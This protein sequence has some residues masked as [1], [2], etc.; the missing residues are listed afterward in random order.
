MLGLNL[1]VYI[2]YIY[3][4]RLCTGFVS[5]HDQTIREQIVYRGVVNIIILF[6][7]ST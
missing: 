4:Q 5:N 7:S 6:E 2:Q 1:P 3:G